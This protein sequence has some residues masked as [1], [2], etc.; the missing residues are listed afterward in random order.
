[1]RCRNH[2]PNRRSAR[3]CDPG[4][5]NYLLRLYQAEQPRAVIV[6][7]DTLEAPTYRHLNFPPIRAGGHLMMRWSSSFRPWP[8]SSAL[9]LCQ[10]E[11]APV[12]RPTTFAAAVAAEERRGG[13]TVVAS[14]DRDTFQLASERDDHSLSGSRGRDGPHRTCRGSRT[15]RCR[16]AASPGLHRLR[17]DPSDRLPGAP[18]L[19]AAGAANVLRKHG[20]LEGALKAGCFPRRPNGC[21]LFRS[22]ATMDRKAPLPKLSKQ[23]PT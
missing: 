12:T 4:F 19:G 16:S 13:R 7:W 21:G 10:R 18:G 2:P 17:G 23:T 22:I 15:L 8:S 3:G 5:A 14:G 9:R 1:M 20:T 11:G 6:G